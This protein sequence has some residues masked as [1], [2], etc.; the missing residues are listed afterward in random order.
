MLLDVRFAWRRLIHSPGFAAAAILTLALGI[1]ANAIVFGFLNAL[2]LQPLPVSRPEELVFLN[3]GA[4]GSGPNFS[5]PNYRD[6]RD[7]ND[8]FSAL[9]AYRLTVMSLAADGRTDRLWGYL[10]T[11]NY[12]DALGVQAIRGRTFT[13]DDDRV[14]GGHPIVVISVFRT[15]LGRT[16]GVLAIGC[17]IGLVSSLLV[18]RLLTPYLYG[19]SDRDP[20]ALAAVAA[21]MTFTAALALW[22]P[23]RRA[24]AVDP[25]IALRAE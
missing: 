21:A 17:A 13:P 3:S 11:G 24:I 16:A 14:P 23:A 4:N 8:V 25:T 19:A 7:R 6:L 9:I 2:I 12:F 5:H 22:M 18:S 1:G 10:V 15:V 20:W